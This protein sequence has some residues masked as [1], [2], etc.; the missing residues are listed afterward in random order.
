[1]T[2]ERLAE[3]ERLCEVASEGPWAV[4][5]PH[6]NLQHRADIVTE[7][8]DDPPVFKSGKRKGQPKRQPE[9]ARIATGFL[10]P[11]MWIG[12]AAFTVAARTAVPELL[13]EVRRLRGAVAAEREACAKVAD[14]YVGRNGDAVADCI[15]EDIRSRP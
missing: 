15:A 5:I 9:P 4:S 11:C 3:L 13:A 6:P 12:D 1:M 2:D 10:V 8:V 7:W 14:G